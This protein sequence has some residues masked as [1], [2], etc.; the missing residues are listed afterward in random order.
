MI[1]R[2]QAAYAASARVLDSVSYKA[3]LARG[4]ALINNEAGELVRSR[5]EVRPGEI[6]G[7]EVSDGRFGATVAGAPPMRKRR[8][9]SLDD[10][11]QGSLF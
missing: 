9:P 1:E 6:L 2:K 11:S 8:K 5:D 3:V 10:G 7:I 4:F